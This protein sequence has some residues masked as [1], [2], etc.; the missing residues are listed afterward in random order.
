MSRRSRV[1]LLV[2]LTVVLAGFIALVHRFVPFYAPSF[3]A[4][5]GIAVL[6]AGLI[7][8]ARPMRWLGIRTRRRALFVAFGGL[9]LAVA[10]L[11]WPA[12][13]LRS[14]GRQRLDDFLPEYQFREYHEGLV[15]APMP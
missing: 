14:A 3:L 1:V 6:L 5:A 11:L 13:V 10:A 7:S 9:A 2:L 4:W 8:I 12:P 15:R